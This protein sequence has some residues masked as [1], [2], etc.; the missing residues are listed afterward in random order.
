MKMRYKF[1]VEAETAL[2]ALICNVKSPSNRLRLCLHIKRRLHAL[3]LWPIRDTQAE[4]TE[5]SIKE[6]MNEHA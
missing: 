1:V 4:I 6:D 5:P 2:C 3:L